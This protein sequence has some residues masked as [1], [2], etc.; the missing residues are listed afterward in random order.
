MAKIV[1]KKK[2]YAYALA[3]AIVRKACKARR[4]TYLAQEA[5]LTVECGCGQTT[6]IY[7]ADYDKA[8]KLHDVTIG[9]CKSCGDTEKSFKI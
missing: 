6:G 4:L 1:V 2:T 3:K 5:D 9:I 7:V 8:G